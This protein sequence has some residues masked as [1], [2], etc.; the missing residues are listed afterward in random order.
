MVLNTVLR[1]KSFPFIFPDFAAKSK[2]SESKELILILE[3][4]EAKAHTLST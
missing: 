3:K 4:K 2:I 1:K